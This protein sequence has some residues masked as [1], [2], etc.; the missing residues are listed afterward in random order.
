MRLDAVKREIE[1]E[2]RLRFGKIAQV[3]GADMVCIVR[4]N[5]LGLAHQ[6]QTRPRLRLA[7]RIMHGQAY[8]RRMVN[9][10]RVFSQRADQNDWPPY[11]VGHTVHERAVRVTGKFCDRVESAP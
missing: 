6:R 3:S 5:Q 8:I 11:M 2:Q 7:A 9:I 4:A 1:R 10:M